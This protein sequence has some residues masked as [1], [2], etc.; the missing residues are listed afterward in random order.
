M[1]DCETVYRSDLTR[2]GTNVKDSTL[3]MTS[4]DRRKEALKEALLKD[5]READIAR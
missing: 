5:R 3:L 4:N 1:S 2:C